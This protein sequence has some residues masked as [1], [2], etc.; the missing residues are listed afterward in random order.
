MLVTPS[1][2]TAYNLVYSARS[3]LPLGLIPNLI[4]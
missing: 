3:K 2:I 1:Q 4:P